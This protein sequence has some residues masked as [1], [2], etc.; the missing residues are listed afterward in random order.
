MPTPTVCIGTSGW[1]YSHWK[2]RFYPKGVKQADWLPYF[3]R[4][5]ETAEVNN[6]FYRIP[7]RETIAQWSAQAP[8]RFRFAIKLWRGITHFKKL[9]NAREPLQ[10]FFDVVGVLPSRQRGPLLVQLPPNQ[11]VDVE[12][13]DRFLDDVRE[14]TAPSRWK[15]TVEFRHESWLCNEVYRLLDRQRAALCLHDMQGRAPVDEPNDASFVYVR[16]H[17]PGGSYAGR[18]AEKHIREEA[19]RIRR[20]LKDGK[21][22]FV[23]YNNDLEGYAV[24]NALQLKEALGVA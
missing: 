18:Y 3:A 16:R 11:K 4:H 20:W 2:E 23:Y 15:V 17:G 22:V 9:K 6:S 24:E 1:N 12:K 19:R 21:S 13:L 10:N 7:K 8:R 5:F 14:V